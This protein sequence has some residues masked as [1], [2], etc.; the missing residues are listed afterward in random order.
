VAFALGK[1][2][3]RFAAISTAFLL[4]SQ[5]GHFPEL[6]GILHSRIVFACFFT[7]LWDSPQWLCLFVSHFNSGNFYTWD[8]FASFTY[9]CSLAKGFL[10]AY[11]L[12]W[13]MLLSSLVLKIPF[14]L[15][16]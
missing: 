4:A 15:E 16:A 14:F 3:E 2:F 7:L 10:A 9:A 8:D 11:E 6:T 13:D 5:C 1:I 12:G